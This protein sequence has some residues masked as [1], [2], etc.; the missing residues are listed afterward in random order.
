MEFQ[1]GNVVKS[2]S[3]TIALVIGY[4]KGQ[5]V[6]FR[7][8]D[9]KWH[10]YHKRWA[11]SEFAKVADTIDDYYRNKYEPSPDAKEHFE[12]VIKLKDYNQIPSFSETEK[13]QAYIDEIEAL[14]S[15]LL[16]NEEEISELKEDKSKLAQHGILLENNLRK[17]KDKVRLLGVTH[18]DEPPRLNRL[19]TL[20]EQVEEITRHLHKP[21]EKQK[22]NLERLDKLEKTLT[23]L[24]S[25]LRNLKIAV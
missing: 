13:E 9:L 24:I 16:Y 20:E 15:T 3:G 11:T 22:E 4:K 7:G 10:S 23:E 21:R 25:D 12:A 17:E 14:K 5:S 19:V 1:K 18:D 8:F 6:V 2:K